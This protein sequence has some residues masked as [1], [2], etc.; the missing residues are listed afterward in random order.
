[1]NIIIAYS[2]STKINF[3]S[4]LIAQR[5]DADTIEI[6]D[7]EVK[8]GLL[9]SVR[10]NLNAIRSTQTDITPE[11]VDFSGYD[12]I[13]IGTQSTFGNPSPA[14][15]TFINNCDFKNKDVI[16]YTTTNSSKGYGVLNVMK[17]NI[18]AKGGRVI[19]SFIMR[20]NNKTQ[21]ELIISTLKLLN[22]L[23]IDI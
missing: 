9:N 10:N 7:L 12:L 3:V 5:I 8:K 18:E 2:S 11:S 20:V 16:I 19:N 13:L 17:Q 1:M 4:E 21:E 6:K 23:D 22:E 15:L 14:I